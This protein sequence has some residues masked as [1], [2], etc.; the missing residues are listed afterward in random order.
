MPV[1]HSFDN[2]AVAVRA[3]IANQDFSVEA[4]TS[5][6]LSRI[7]A[8]NGHI[9]AVRFVL[10]D[11]ALSAARAMDVRIG[12]GDTLPPL[13]GLPLIIK[14]NCDTAGAVCFSS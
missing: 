11:Q 2:S 1:A 12:A 10:G 5:Q 8:G 6:F 7:A 13:A 9:G 14:E 4:L 3:A